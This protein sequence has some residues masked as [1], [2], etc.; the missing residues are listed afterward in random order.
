MKKMIKEIHGLED[1]FEDIFEDI[2]KGISTLRMIISSSDTAEEFCQLM[3]QRYHNELNEVT[4][5]K[6]VVELF[7]GVE[8]ERFLGDGFCIPSLCVFDFDCL[9]KIHEEQKMIFSKDDI[10]KAIKDNIE[11]YRKFCQNPNADKKLFENLGYEPDNDEI[12][13]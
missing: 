11:R 3:T 8:N 1:V 13:G 5:Y 6:R 10:I 7:A 12:G 4:A 9:D 2:P